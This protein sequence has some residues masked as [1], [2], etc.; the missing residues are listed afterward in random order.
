[1][2]KNQLSEKQQALLLKE[3]ALLP[4]DSIGR[5]DGKMMGLLCRKWG[6]RPYQVQALRNKIRK[7]G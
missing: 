4:K 6:V 5:A 1:M 7:A 2:L 3:Y